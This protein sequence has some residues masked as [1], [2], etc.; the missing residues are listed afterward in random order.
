MSARVRSV[1]IEVESDDGGATV[2]LRRTA[3]GLRAM[4][5]CGAQGG[6][7]HLESALAGLSEAAALEMEGPASTSTRSTSSGPPIRD[8]ARTEPMLADL[9]VLIEAM[10]RASAGEV[11]TAVDEALRAATAALA[12]RPFPGVARVLARVSSTL[13][14]RGSAME[15]ALAIIALDEVAAALEGA[16]GEEARAEVT[17]V[18]AEVARLDD[19]ELV[20]VARARER[21]N[22]LW[23]TRVLV[24]P[25]G[26]AVYREEGPAGSRSLST[27]LC[28]RRVLASLA[29]RQLS[30]DPAR[31]ALMQ[32]ALEPAAPG[33]LLRR[34]AEAASTTMRVPAELGA[35]PLLGVACPRL[36]WLA[37]AAVTLERGAGFVADASGN[38]IAIDRAR[39]PGAFDALAEL[40]DGGGDI[41]A[42]AAALH[43][44]VDGVRLVPWSALVERDRAMELAILTV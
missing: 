30:G 11:T 12:L 39:D 14:A 34:A 8:L 33:A 24:D 21:G 3:G 6:C 20:E 35:A 23:E 44:D 41:R 32:Y 31:L 2:V 17:G 26:G 22:L 40:L 43:V 7:V 19:L 15:T 4:C 27:G 10:L 29:S 5:S 13:G 42:I 25:G 37:P 1:T 16:R 38:R 28:G 36:A 18:G 9:R